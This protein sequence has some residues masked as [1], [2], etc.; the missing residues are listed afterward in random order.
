MGLPTI[1]YPGPEEERYTL[2][3]DDI[4]SINEMMHVTYAVHIKISSPE[5]GLPQAR[6]QFF[7]F[8]PGKDKMWYTGQGDTVCEA[9]DHWF[10]KTHLRR[11][12]VSAQRIERGWDY[13][14]G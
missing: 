10:Q 5:R 9:T 12:D 13:L 3:S 6:K 14:P 2:T 8:A 1:S 11:W 4:I 7:I